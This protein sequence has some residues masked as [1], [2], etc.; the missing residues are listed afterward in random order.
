MSAS[1]SPFPWSRRLRAV[2]SSAWCV[3]VFVALPLSATAQQASVSPQSATPPDPA[4]WQVSLRDLTRVE[5]WRFFDPPPSGGNP[6]YTFLGNRLQVEVR[7]TSRRLDMTLTAQHVGFLGLPDDASGPGPLGTGAL[8]FAQGDGTAHP[9]Q[10]YLRYA[11]VRVRNVVPGLEVQVGRMAYAS[12]AEAPSGIAKI[13]AVKRQ[14]LDAR[15]VGEFE[16]SLYQRGYDGVRVDWIRPVYRLTGMAL[17]PTQGGFARLANPTMTDVRVFGATLSATG[18]RPGGGTQVQGFVLRYDDS[19]PVSGR[20]DNSGR[21]ASAVDVGVTTFG[22]VALGAYPTASG[23][24]DLMFWGAVQRGRW[25]D[26]DHKA[27]AL[28]VEAGHQWP[29]V[30]WAPWLRGGLFIASGDNDPDDDTH[31]TFFP[32]LPTIRRFSQTTMYSTMN[33]HEFFGQVLLRPRPALGLR[34]DVH[35]VRLATSEDRW[36]AGSGATLTSGG[37]FGYA[38][39][40]SRGGRTLDRKSVV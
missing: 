17:M 27:Y 5:S 39:R 40:P 2:S 22:G 4:V 7:R 33:L 12:G 24:A 26:D 3:A 14:R 30:T 21:P 6:D 29:D 35:H 1:C 38:G 20:P 16:W 15:L 10:L 18:A 28:A 13:E 36:Y 34:L 31:G 9:Q 37:G 32:M 19:R 23:V 25:Y 11:N 8:Y